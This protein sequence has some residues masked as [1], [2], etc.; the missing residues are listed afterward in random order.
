M[1]FIKNRKFCDSSHPRSKCPDYG[2]VCYVCNKKNHFKVFCPHIGKTFNSQNFTYI[3]QTKN[4]NTGWSIPLPSNAIPVSYKIGT[5]AQCNVI[6]LTILKT[7]DPEPDLCP[8][9]IKLSTF[10]NSEIPVLGKCIRKIII[11]HKKEHFDV[12]LI[13]VN[14]KSV[15]ILGLS[16]IMKC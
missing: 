14:S 2:N 8:M 4:E 7:F 3:N 5:G 9:N 16:T 6:P 13:V 1:D 11:M 10:N 15:P 12:S